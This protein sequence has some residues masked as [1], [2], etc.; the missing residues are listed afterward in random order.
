MPEMAVELGS[1]VPG[2]PL[3]GWLVGD[4]ARILAGPRVTWAGHRPCLTRSG[5]PRRRRTTAYPRPVST[6]AVR[7]YARG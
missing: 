4:F 2:G 1:V 6:T 3:S 7:R 5:S